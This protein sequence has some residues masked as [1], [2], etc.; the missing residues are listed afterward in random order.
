MAGVSDTTMMKTFLSTLTRLRLIDKAPGGMKLN[1]LGI[2][3]AKLMLLR[4]E[5]GK[6][7]D[8]VERKWFEGSSGEI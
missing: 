4:A 1:P 7:M 8:T 3:V 6:P 2:R 5:Q